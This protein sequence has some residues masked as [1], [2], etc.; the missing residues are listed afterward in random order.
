MHIQCSTYLCFIFAQMPVYRIPSS[1]QKQYILD[2]MLSLLKYTN[3][4]QTYFRL[5]QS[6]RTNSLSQRPTIHPFRC[7]STH[8]PELT[9]VVLNPEIRVGFRL[10]SRFHLEGQICYKRQCAGMQVGTCLQQVCI[11]MPNHRDFT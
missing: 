6:C 10:L 8:R 4:L 5:Q 7:C 2:I 1:V 3:F 9:P 11:S